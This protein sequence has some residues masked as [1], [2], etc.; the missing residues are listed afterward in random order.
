[1][2]R[3][4]TVTISSTNVSPC[5]RRRRIGFPAG[6]EAI[7]LFDLA[8]IG[9][10]PCCIGLSHLNNGSSAGCG[11]LLLRAVQSRGT[12][13]GNCCLAGSLGLKSKNANHA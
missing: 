7:V 3:I 12:G 9:P 13:N 11:Q 6:C 4:A 10:A 2:E 1:M 5:S 8:A